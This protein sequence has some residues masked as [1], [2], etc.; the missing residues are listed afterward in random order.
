MSAY[1]LNN[2]DVT[3]LVAAAYGQL[4]GASDISS[5]TLKN[6]ID[7]GKDS[8]I[9]NSK[10]AFTQTLANLIYDR[11]YT[12]DRE[13]DINENDSFYV[14]AD[15]WGG[16][17]AAVSVDIPTTL[18]ENR[19]WQSFVS[20]TTTIGTSTV[21]LPLCEEK[22]F[23]RSISWSLPISIT[24][25][26][27][28]TALLSEEGMS[29][30]VNAIYVACRNSIKEHRLAMDRA[31]R[32]N[33]IAELV[34]YAA[35]QSATGIHVIELNSLYNAYIGNTTTSMTKEEFLNTPASMIFAAKTLDEYRGYLEEPSVL[36][37]VDGKDRFIP[38]GECVVQVLSTFE[39]QLEYGIK[40][41]VY[42]NNIVALP[43][44]RT[45]TAWQGFGEGST[46]DE[47]ST[48]YVKTASTADAGSATE[49]NGVVAFMCHP[50]AIMH[51]IVK[52][53]VATQYYTME[54]IVH[55]EYQFVDR[56]ANNLGMPAIVFRL[57]DFTVTPS[58]GGES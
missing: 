3:S 12:T 1:V 24:R 23:G 49:V 7:E 37:N 55:T 20:G 6:I 21:Y 22:L 26:M 38:R 51:T 27:W 13:L 2:N 48:I 8:D 36:F 42:H 11:I 9:M 4:T 19:A 56:Y 29:R 16:I 17:L 45:V 10:E 5:L 25:E 18:L 30:L 31:N 47:L 14:R 41:D 58:G 34:N 46:F 44:H 57:D 15:E 50:L 43:N 32:N 53:R 54:D 33:F 52:E 28:N 35:G 40:S 39:K